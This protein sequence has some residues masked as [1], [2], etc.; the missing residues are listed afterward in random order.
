MLITELCRHTGVPRDATR[1]IEITLSSFTDIWCI[2]AEY[3]QEEADR[4][5]VAPVETSLEVDIDSIHAKAS[6][7]TPTPEPSGKSSPTSFSQSPG[8]ST[9][10]Q[11]AR[12]TQAMIRKMGHLAHS[13][14]VRA[15]LLEATVP[16]MIENVI[17]AIL[18]PLQAPIDTLTI[19]VDACESR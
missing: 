10:S 19:R 4:R 18:T 1:D 7:A 17:L 11:P 3:T 14:D 5:R 12:I 8:T 13:D 16:W 6:S 15:T 2:E 9:S